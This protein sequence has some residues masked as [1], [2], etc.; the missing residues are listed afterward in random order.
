MLASVNGR[1]AVEMTGWKRGL[2]LVFFPWRLT[3]GVRIGRIDFHVV[4]SS[5]ERCS[6]E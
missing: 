1:E 3:C 2:G 5:A 6:T 4:S